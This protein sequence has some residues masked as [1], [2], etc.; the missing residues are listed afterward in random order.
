MKI[1]NP[2]I[3]AVIITNDNP[4]VIEAIKSVYESVTEIIL[5]NTV[6]TT[7]VK[8][9]TKLYTKVRYFYFKWVDDYS[10]AR[11]YGIKRAK[12]DWILTIDSDEILREKIEYVD[13]KYL[14]YMSKQVSQGHGFPTARLFQNHKG[15][16]YK[17]RVHETIDHAITAETSCNSDIVVDHSG[18]DITPEALQKKI[19]YYDSLMLKDKKNV[20]YNRYM[21]CYWFMRKDYNKAMSFFTKAMKDRLNDAHFAVIQNNIHACHFMLEHS[22]NVLIETLRRSLMFEPFQMYARV[23]I[24]EHLLSQLNDENKE[25]YLPQIRDEVRKIENIFQN[26]LSNLLYNEMEMTEEYIQEKYTELSKWEKQS[27]LAS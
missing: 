14:A 2:N 27:K 9:L 10:K 11:N 22:L 23:N 4:L 1:I 5:V 8:E 18:Y 17:N 15:I 19:A 3:S 24:V 12:G 20:I 6:K 21:G 16:F 13:D 26:K 25:M 7:K